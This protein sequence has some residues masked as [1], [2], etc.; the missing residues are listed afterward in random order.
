M[1]GGCDR[2]WINNWVAKLGI[3]PHHTWLNSLN[4]A[5]RQRISSLRQVQWTVRGCSY[6]IPPISCDHQPVHGVSGRN[7][8]TDSPTPPPSMAALRW[9]HLCHLA[10]WTRG[11]AMV[12]WTHQQIAPQ[13]Y[14]Y[15]WTREGRQTGLSRRPG[16]QKPWRIDHFS[17]QE[18]HSH[19]LLHPFPFT[20]PPENNHRCV[21]V[22]AGQGLPD[23]W[24]HTLGTELQHHQQIF[25]ANGFPDY[26]VRKTLAHRPPSFTPS[27]STSEEPQKILCPLRQRIKWE[28]RKGLHPAWGQGSIQA[29]EDAQ[30][31]HEETY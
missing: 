17:L 12:S 18:T 22:N 15:H 10:T 26:L 28:A 27:S 24:H 25:Q 9:R 13:H 20:L 4:F 2:S 11:A 21:K 30:T 23:L 14:L 31:D 5:Y 19:W 1:S 16:S 29:H 6:G 3:S 8:F 7:R